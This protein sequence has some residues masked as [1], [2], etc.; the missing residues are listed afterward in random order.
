MSYWLRTYGT[1]AGFLLLLL[2]FAGLRPDVFLSLNNLRNITEQVA[3]L[4]IAATL[5]TV[6]M[7]VGDFDLSIGA[8]ASLC[9]VVVADRLIAGW[10]LLPSLGIAL[11]VGAAGGLING[12]LVAYAGLSA[13]VATLA[14]MTIYRGASLWYTAGGTLFSGIPEAFRPIGQGSTLGL[15]NPVWIML[16]IFVVVWVTLEQ[17]TLGRRWYAIGGNKLA[18]YLVGIN[19]QWL[20]M[21]AFACTGLGAAVAGIVLTSRLF[22]AHPTAGEPLMLN[23]IAAVFL[24]MTMFREGEAHV[25]GTIFGVLIL[26]V[27]NNGLNILGIDSYVQSMLTGLIIILAVMA[28]GLAR[29]RE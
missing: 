21:L 18:S 20:R 12:W 4:A 24:G 26:G 7:V 5:M 25:L 8:L 23:S 2:A 11:A 9:G 3:I 1:F 29:R 27:L 16:L 6:V 19:V 15:P 10:G 14:T 28:S 17:T 13:F 22:S